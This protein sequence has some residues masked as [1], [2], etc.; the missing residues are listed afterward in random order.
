MPEVE[1]ER[2]ESTAPEARIEKKDLLQ[3]IKNHEG[4]LD[5][6]DSEEWNEAHE[7]LKSQGIDP[8]A[9]DI[10]QIEPHEMKELRDTLKDFEN[11][12]VGELD[13]KE[14]CEKAMR[15]PK[16][17]SSGRMEDLFTQLMDLPREET[18]KQKLEKVQNDFLGKGVPSKKGTSPKTLYE[19]LYEKGTLAE[20]LM[21]P[22]AQSMFSKNAVNE[23]VNKFKEHFRDSRFKIKLGTHKLLEEAERTEGETEQGEEPPSEETEEKEEVPEKTISQEGAMEKGKAIEESQ[24]KKL[25]SKAAE[26]VEEVPKEVRKAMAKEFK[27]AKI[28]KRAGDKCRWLLEYSKEP[29]A[30]NRLQEILTEREGEVWAEGRHGNLSQEEERKLMTWRI[31][32]QVEGGTSWKEQTRRFRTLKKTGLTEE[33]IK[34][35]LKDWGGEEGIEALKEAKKEAPEL[36]EKPPK[37]I[38]RKKYDELFEDAD[39]IVASK[40]ALKT[41]SEHKEEM[42]GTLG[43][44]KVK[45]N[46]KN[47]VVLRPEFK[48]KYAA[49]SEGWRIEPSKEFR[50]KML[51]Q[52]PNKVLKESGY[53]NEP[54]EL[55]KRIEMIDEKKIIGAAHTHPSK[56]A[57]PSEMASPSTEDLI[58]WKRHGVAGLVVPGNKEAASTTVTYPPEKHSSDLFGRKVD[59]VSEEKIKDLMEAPSGEKGES[60]PRQKKTIRRGF[61]RLGEQGH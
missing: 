41:A 7:A 23:V 18:I 6:I 44:H 61:G 30:S 38:V 8:V 27:E 42:Q 9:S 28:R 21:E 31:A 54:K 32:R 56:Y 19:K 3:K 59:F 15:L 49:G 46:D 29:S 13:W 40:Q 22:Q 52:G 20:V 16:N 53:N 37:E 1:P 45:K 5:E 36:L 55:K 39:R 24:E 34:K 60:H 47:I 12:R 26:S 51:F 43:A 35:R 17:L 4:R 25:I 2:Y 11:T 14:F 33:E 58:R 10:S 57:R 48:E 50:E